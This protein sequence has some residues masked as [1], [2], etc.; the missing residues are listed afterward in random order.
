M[1]RIESDHD[2][3]TDIKEPI[4]D[5]KDRLRELYAAYVEGQVRGVL[6]LLEAENASEA[7][8]RDDLM[9][10]LD[11]YGFW[12]RVQLDRHRISYDQGLPH[13]GLIRLDH[14][15][16]STNNSTVRF[17]QD[18]QADEDDRNSKI[19]VYGVMASDF[20]MG[21]DTMWFEG[22][23]L[24]IDSKGNVE[25]KFE[26]YPDEGDGVLPIKK[27]NSLDTLR[28]LVAIGVNGMALQE[29]EEV[30][31]YERESG[32]MLVKPAILTAQEE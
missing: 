14:S 22:E 27:Y 2:A 7:E 29:Q 12:G 8:L 17:Y 4:S 32:R 9:T 21:M 10:I 11:T 16:H 28:K 1:N 6:E 19:E 15:D 24:S 23:H 13:L 20:G 5:P 30:Y 18:E 3:N 31:K 25:Q 26:Y